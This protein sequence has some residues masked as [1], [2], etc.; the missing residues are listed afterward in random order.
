VDLKSLGKYTL[1][2]QLEPEGPVKIYQALDLEANR[3]V[4]IKLLSPNVQIGA[5]S[6]QEFQSKVTALRHPYLV[7]VYEVGLAD[8][9]PFLVMEDT[10]GRPLAH[11][12]AQLRAQQ[13]TLPLAQVSWTLGLIAAALDY[14]HAQGV[15]HGNLN[16]SNILLTD[17]AEPI[18]TDFGLARLLL[19]DTVPFKP[20]GS[21][22]GLPAY[23]SPEQANGQ[24][25]DRLSDL[26]AL[27]VILYELVTGRPPF[28]AGSPEAILKQQR[29]ELPPPL[30]TFRADLPEAAQAVILKALAKE[31]RQRFANARELAEGFASALAE[32]PVEKGPA[33]VVMPQAIGR[34]K[35]E[36]ELGRR[37]DLII[38]RAH[39]TELERQVVIRILLPQ[40]GADPDFRARFQQE[41]E[42]ISALKHRYVVE[43]YDFGEYEGR[44][45]V[46]MPYLAGGSLETRL[47]AGPLDLQILT[48]IIERIAA[49]LDEAHSRHIIH[50]QVMPGDILFDRQG[51]AYL[52]DFSLARLFDSWADFSQ[53]ASAAK[54]VNYMSPEQVGALLEKSSVP[55]DGR[56]DIYSLGVLLFEALTGQAPYEAETVYDT[57]MAHLKAP[58]PLLRKL[59]PELPETYQTLIN[60]TLAKDPADRYATAGAVANHM[61][62]LLS[63]RWYMSKISGVISKA[64]K[65]APNIE[66]SVS[67]AS[68]PVL[69][70]STFGRYQ[71]GRELGRGGMGVVYLAYDPETKRQV[72]L[73]V[74]LDHLAATPSFRQQFQ[75]E[76]KL[77]ARLAHE[78]IAP[79]YDF[80][81]YN[82]QPF[83]VIPYLAGGTL[84]AKLAQGQ[85]RLKSSQLTPII[86]RV[87]L[88]L[89]EA[90]RHNIIHQDVK[91]GNILFNDKGEAFLSDFGIAVL[92][93]SDLAVEN[94]MGGTPQYM[95]PEQIKVIM[96]K[97]GREILDGR[98][99]IYALGVVLFE[100]LT[101]R[102]PYPAGTP[103][104]IALAHLNRPVPRL[105]EIRPDLPAAYQQIIDQA[106]AKEPA[107]RYQTGQA[108]AKD[109]QELAGGRWYLRQLME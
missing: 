17:V 62:E 48:P 69:S 20:T 19:G 70:G 6:F 57:A 74:L 2:K 31:P 71:L 49:A 24:P 106:L 101:G 73:K 16:P 92:Q 97:E 58:I 30:R 1:T 67:S 105:A 26:Y 34:Y 88:A 47:Q 35:F 104:E 96:K 21:G 55:V 56:S 13:R 77:I 95:S 76:A 80:G 78:Y 81:A 41:V 18:L 27:G 60:R 14:A 94:R 65:P 66:P 53:Q 3:T 61:Q 91:P 85:R 52:S 75:H 87:A 79:I 90:H 8:N 89:D 109:I 82:N 108:L 50:G 54:R 22:L 42:L 103:R 23:I 37:D 32:T 46:V 98:S 83:I 36:A 4:I 102:V 100:M 12:L 86:K 51:Q 15:V 38:Y 72:A 40:F 43:V 107:Q 29:H 33:S 63:G 9:C 68:P 28:E 84:A 59:K 45:Y 25:G 7:H 44:P 11:D 64:A 39:D 5:R 93:V 10:Q 99:D